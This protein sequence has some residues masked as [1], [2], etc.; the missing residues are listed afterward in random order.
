MVSV[1]DFLSRLIYSVQIDASLLRHPAKKRV[2]VCNPEGS[3]QELRLLKFNRGK[4]E[5]VNTLAW[6]ETY[7][8]PWQVRTNLVWFGRDMLT[9]TMLCV[10]VSVC[11]WGSIVPS[12]FFLFYYIFLHVWAHRSG[13]RTWTWRVDPH[14]RSDWRLLK[15]IFQIFLSFPV[16]SLLLN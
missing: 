14:M 16:N 10:S 9:A 7:Q 2:W 11:C 8:V 3:E 1:S 13:F 12:T 4:S 6:I 5:G 15:V